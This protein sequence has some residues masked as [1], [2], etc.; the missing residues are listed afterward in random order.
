GSLLTLA[1]DVVVPV[2]ERPVWI[3]TPRPHVQLEERSQVVAVRTPHELERLTLEHR[4]GVVIA[5]PCLRIDDVLDADQAPANTGGL[6]DQRLGPRRVDLAVDHKR[7]ID[8]MDA[9]RAMVRT[10]DAAECRPI[11][12]RA[13]AVDVEKL[14]GRIT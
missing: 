1:G 14:P 3:V 2:D 11:T 7:A 12:C 10:A 5:Q 13:G 4:R 8:V 6:V 9:H